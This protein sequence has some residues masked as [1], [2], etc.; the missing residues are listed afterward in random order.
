MPDTSGVQEKSPFTQPQFEAARYMIARMAAEAAGRVMA[1]EEVGM[2]F[3]PLG[4]FP[5]AA[6][7]NGTVITTTDFMRASLLMLW[8]LIVDMA[9]MC[10]TTPSEVIAAVG[11]SLA[12]HDPA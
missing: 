2:R 3:T 9:D 12:E 6:V 8:S 10:E 5:A 4:D 7:D 11:V 1:P